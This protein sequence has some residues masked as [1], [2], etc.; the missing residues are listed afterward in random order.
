MNRITLVAR[1]DFTETLRSK[2]FLFGLLIAPLL[3]ALMAFV[4]PRIMQSHSPQTSGEVKVIDASGAVFDQIRVALDPAVLMARAEV[5][6]PK[7]TAEIRVPRFTLLRSQADIKLEKKW[8]IQ[9]DATQTS[10]LALIVIRRDSLFNQDVTRPDYEM[11]VS[12]NLNDAT[13]AT[14]NEGVSRA[15]ISVRLAND[16]IDQRTVESLSRVHPPVAIVVSSHGETSSL[17]GYRKF[18]PIFCG[19][20]LFISVMT[21]GQT[22]M[23]S[24]VEEKSSRVVEVLLAAASPLEL[25]W[26]KLIGQLGLGL[27]MMTIYSGM[28][29]IAG[30]QFALLTAL[31]PILIVYLVVFYLI[32]YLVYGALMLS[33]GA[34]VNQVADAQSMLSPVV[35]MLVAPL[36]LSPMIGQSP[37]STLSVTLS[38]IPPINTFA[39]LARIVSDN[40]PPTWQVLL[41]ILVGLIS[42]AAAVWFASK[43]F[44]IGLLMH[45]KAPTFGTLIRWARMS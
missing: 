5:T 10:H 35:L 24:T 30:S 15:L 44:R 11:Y 43:V 33:I 31:Q 40:P 42:A 2:G 37:S 38:F 23:T 41:T 1:R 8:L 16:G 36:A 28:G 20:L 22:L 34:A 21:G 9:N 14:I 17:R 3:I 7:S 12:K 25:M 18:L 39:M 27:F 29:L 45:G 6:N 4:M 19:V 32:S 26:G 13:E